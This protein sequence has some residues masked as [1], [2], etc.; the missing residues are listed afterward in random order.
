MSV[1]VR[2]SN[3]GE[4]EKGVCIC[5][6]VDIGVGGMKVWVIAKISIALGL[7]VGGQS[8][9]PTS[10]QQKGE[11]ARIVCLVHCLVSVLVLKIFNLLQ[12]LKMIMMQ[13]SIIMN[14]KLQI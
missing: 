2:G 8:P 1:S 4:R 3:K 12:L 13:S 10:Q 9:P 7:G 5:M 6:R 11:K 14:Y